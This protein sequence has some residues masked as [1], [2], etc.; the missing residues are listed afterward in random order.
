MDSAE[1]SVGHTGMVCD[2]STRFNRWS[3]NNAHPSSLIFKDVNVTNQYGA[4][5]V[6]FA[7]KRVTHPFGWMAVLAAGQTYMMEYI[8][9][10]HI[11]NISYDGVIY[12]MQVQSWAYKEK[13]RLTLYVLIFLEGTQTYIYILCHFSILIL[14]R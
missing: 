12:A 1:F 8:N 7:I 14:R 11:T 6:P 5:L 9:A 2:N 10:N 3:W 13:S 4:S